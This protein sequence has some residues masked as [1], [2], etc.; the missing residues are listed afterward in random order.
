M[1]IDQ[2][3]YLVILNGISGFGPKTINSILKQNIKLQ[4]LWEMDSRELEH[5]G[6][7][8]RKK[9]KL[10]E[11]RKKLD[12]NKIYRSFK[13]REFNYVT[14]IDDNY[15][16]KLHQIYDPPPVL[17]YKGKNLFDLPSA[18]VV[19]SR[20]STI[21]GRKVT[22][23]I[24]RK[25]ADK[26]INIISGMAKGIDSTAHRGALKSDFKKTTAV[27][28]AGFEYIYPSEN[29]MLAQKIK[30]NGMLVSEFN[31]N[32]SPTPGN[33]PRRNRIISGLA[34]IVL[35]MEAGEKSGSLITVNF[36]LE[37]GK[38]VMALPGNIDR[39][40]SRGTNKLIK[41]GAAVITSVQDVLDHLNLYIQKY[42]KKK[43]NSRDKKD[44]IY[45]D[46]NYNEKKLLQIFQHEVEI[47]YN[48][49]KSISGFD[50]DIL[51]RTLVS[52]EFKNLI[53]HKKGKKYIYKGLQNLL[54]PI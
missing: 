44:D 16:Q 29:K 54:K 31:P 32:I 10:I 11:T 34:D 2:S 1:H 39:P 19:G 53:I 42:D 23:N 15:P 35:V 37:Q 6:I 27:M 52:L 24:A 22:Y 4:Y 8:G 38:D 9:R 40:T 20:N 18:A 3:F 50:S 25:L 17:F 33:F 21:Y 43:E 12:I 7:K 28:G 41:D 45:P 51:D 14:I 5:T 48:Q 49:I 13:N 46:L 47:N 30:Q 26:N 36:A